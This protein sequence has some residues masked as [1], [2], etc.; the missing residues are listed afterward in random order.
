MIG[1]CS[2]GQAHEMGVGVCLGQQYLTTILYSTN[3]LLHLYI[4]NIFLRLLGSL[5]SVPK[6]LAES[7]FAR[8]D[9]DEAVKWTATD[10]G[11]SG[12]MAGRYFF[13]DG[14]QVIVSKMDDLPDGGGA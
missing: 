11:W 12:P 6:S 4:I 3:K 13:A 1:I 14:M 2:L 7:G 5:V 10:S 9:P 8:V